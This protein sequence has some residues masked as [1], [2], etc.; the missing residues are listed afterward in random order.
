[1]NFRAWQRWRLVMAW[2]WTINTLLWTGA[3]SLTGDRLGYVNAALSVL[4]AVLCWAIYFRRR[5]CS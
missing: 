5:G 4:L 2:C 1:M 3:A